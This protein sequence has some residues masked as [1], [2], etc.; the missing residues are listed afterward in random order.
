MY[1]FKKAFTFVELLIVIAIIGVLAAVIFVRVSN[2]SSQ[3]KTAAALQTMRSILP[4]AT[5]CYMKT[6]SLNTPAKDAYVCGSSGAT[7]PDLNN[8]K[9]GYIYNGGTVSS[10]SALGDKTITCDA[11]TAKCTVT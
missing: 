11:A 2:S 4:Y 6:S 8:A 10:Y 3:S 7:F 9:T 1:N 5:E